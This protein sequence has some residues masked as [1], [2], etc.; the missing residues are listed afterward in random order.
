M[1]GWISS[2]LAKH[3]KYY[4]VCSN[5]GFHTCNNDDL[6]S[7]NYCPNCGER[8]TETGLDFDDFYERV[9]VRAFVKKDCLHCKHH[10]FSDMYLECSKGYGKLNEN[11]GCENWENAIDV[12]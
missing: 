5:C 7:F 8:M 1:A 6:S 3:W 9:G 2:P 12:D 11:K 4:D 10:M